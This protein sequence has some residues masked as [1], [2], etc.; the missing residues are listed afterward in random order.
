MALAG[1]LGIAGLSGCG[2]ESPSP[3][4]GKTV[5]AVMPSCQPKGNQQ[6]TRV[7]ANMRVDIIADTLGVTPDQI[8]RGAYGTATCDRKISPDEIVPGPTDI[9]VQG[10]GNTCLAIGINSGV[11]APSTDVFAICAAP[12]RTVKS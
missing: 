6:W 2:P 3:R 8:E 1:A 7:P 5:D 11:L 12:E 4:P 9:T 10:I